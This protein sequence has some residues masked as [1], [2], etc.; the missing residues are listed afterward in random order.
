MSMPKE[1]ADETKTIFAS[2]NNF[3]EALMR[4]Y[5]DPDQYKKASVGIQYLQQIGLVQEYTSKFYT[6]SSKMEWDDNTLTAIYY[7]EL[8]DPVKDELSW[9]EISK[10]MDKIVEKAIRIDNRLQERKIEKR[11]NSFTWVPNRRT[12]K[13]RTVYPNTYYGPR[14]MEIDMAQH[15]EWR[16]PKKAKPETRYFK[17]NSKCYNCDK[18]GHF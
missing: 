14:P 11:G 17:S 18:K 10:D 16:K 12:E 7:K 8:K 6:L 15:Q 4:I 2:F 13:Q 9:D 5:G 1:Q 3:K